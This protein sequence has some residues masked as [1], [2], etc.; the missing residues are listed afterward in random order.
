MAVSHLAVD[1]IQ[2]NFR[3]PVVLIE[4]AEKLVGLLL[5]LDHLDFEI[6]RLSNSDARFDDQVEAICLVLSTDLQSCRILVL[7]ILR[8]ALDRVVLTCFEGLLLDNQVVTHLFASRQIHYLVL[9][10]SDDP[11]EFDIALLLIPGFAQEV[12]SSF[13]IQRLCS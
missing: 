3:R 9:I 4:V 7:L 11:S 10:I 8:L 13:C 1:A 12:L 2:L 5:L 6:C